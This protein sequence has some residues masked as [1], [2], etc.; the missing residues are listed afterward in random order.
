MSHRADPH[1]VTPRTVQ[2]LAEA[3]VLRSEVWRLTVKLTAPSVLPSSAAV[4]AQPAMN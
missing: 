4:V 1:W 3:M 2:P